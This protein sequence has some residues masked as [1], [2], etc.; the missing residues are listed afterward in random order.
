M[1]INLY[2]EDYDDNW[3]ALIYIGE[4]YISIKFC[5][6]TTKMISTPSNCY[7]DVEPG[8]S[9]PEYME[10]PKEI[11]DPYLSKSNIELVFDKD[12]CVNK[13]ISKKQYDWNINS[14]SPINLEIESFGDIANMM[15]WAVYKGYDLYIENFGKP[16]W[17]PKGYDEFRNKENIKSIIE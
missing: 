15:D 17:K 13:F 6:I 14:S 8:L 3:V 12:G 2:K 1:R 16:S 4:E 5:E 11:Q 7:F 9:F 10:D